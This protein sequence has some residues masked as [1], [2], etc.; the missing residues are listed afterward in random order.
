MFETLSIKQL[1]K[2]VSEYRH[3]HNIKGYS[4]MKRAQLVTELEKRFVFRDN[5]LY[6]K[7]ETGPRRIAPQIVT[8]PIHHNP[9]FA[10]P[11]NTV[12]TKGQLRV[13]NT[14]NNLE[15]R[16]KNT[17]IDQAPYLSFKLHK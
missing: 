1:K 13:E 9:V 17:N 15:A 11:Q 7:G 6:H 14:I 12:K 3:E 5:K 10:A 8:S 4:K 2:L 16:Y